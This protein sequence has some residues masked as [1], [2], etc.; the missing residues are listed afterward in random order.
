[1]SWCKMFHNISKVLHHYQYCE[2]HTHMHKQTLQDKERDTGVRKHRLL[3]S[4]VRH[5]KWCETPLGTLDKQV[6]N[7]DNGRNNKRKTKTKLKYWQY[8]RKLHFYASLCVGFHVC[9]CECAV[10]Q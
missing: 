4:R 2:D 7:T 1:M 3:L 6:L 5:S 8:A 9:R 10:E